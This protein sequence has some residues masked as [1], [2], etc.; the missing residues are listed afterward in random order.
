M[1]VWV[2][3]KDK[4]RA[5]EI[6]A[7]QEAPS[8]PMTEKLRENCKRAVHVIKTDGE[9]LRSGRAILFVLQ[10]LGIGFGFPRLLALPP[11][12]WFVEIGY[13]IVARNRPFFS[14]FLFTEKQIDEK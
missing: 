6:D 5:F 10:V 3:R 9:I 12:I 1:S 8:P 13:F 14:R 4:N 2:R 7:Y 11:F